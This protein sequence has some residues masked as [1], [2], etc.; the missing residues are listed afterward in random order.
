[1]S[2]FF[3]L[4]VTV[5]AALTLVL[6]NAMPALAHETRNVGQYKVVVGWANEPPY[7]G[8]ANAVEFTVTNAQTGKPVDGLDQTVKAT[9]K[10]GGLAPVSLTL[11]ASDETPGLY[12]ASVVPTR[13]GGYAF[14]FTGKIE[15]QTIDETFS[16]GPN[17]FDDVNSIQAI[18]YPDKV[19]SGSDLSTQLSDLQS[20]LSQ[21]RIVAMVAIAFGLL[22][23]GLTFRPRKG[24]ETF[25]PAGAD[26]HRLRRPRAR[27]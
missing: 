2:R 5:V 16:S 6:V 1:M 18:Q 10:A 14:H 7:A 24:K 21:V 23:I 4:A 22:A 12:E 15:S 11:A 9:I 19:P 27:C 17:T 8:V 26:I 3:T 20:G 13:E 25:V